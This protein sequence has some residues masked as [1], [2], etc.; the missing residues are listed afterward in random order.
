M[1]VTADAAVIPELRPGPDWSAQTVTVASVESAAPVAPEA[2]AQW[3][4]VRT[5]RAV[6]VAMVACRVPPVL[7]ALPEPEVRVDQRDRPVFRAMVVMV[8]TAATVTP[9]ARE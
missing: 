7:A 3:E 2:W 5:Q 4:R 9:V 1:A 6:P 8:V